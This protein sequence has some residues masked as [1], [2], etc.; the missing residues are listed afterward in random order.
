MQALKLNEVLLRVVAWHN[1]HPLARRIGPSQVHSIGEVLLPFASAQPLSGGVAAPAAPAP[2]ELARWAPRPLPGGA[3]ARPA[4]PPTPAPTPPPPTDQ[5]GPVPAAVAAAEAAET[6]DFDPFAPDPVDGAAPTA[7][8]AVDAAP[9]PG[10][11]SETDAAPDPARA[12]AR[13][14]APSDDP[15]AHLTGAAPGL[16]DGPPAPAEGPAVPAIDDA[17]DAGLARA[18]A[19]AAS[20]APPA[21]AARPGLLRRLL[22]RLRTALTGRRPG[23]PRLK[24][25]FSRDFIWPLTPRQVARWAQRHGETQPLAPADWPRREVDIDPAR[26]TG[27][28]QQG[29][30]HSVQLHLLTAAIGVG[31]RR[32]RVLMDAH[33]AI[34]GPRAYSRPR[35]ASAAVLVAAVVLSAGWGLRPAAVGG[36]ADTAMLTTLAAS[37]VDAAASAASAAVA[38]GPASAATASDTLLAATPATAEASAPVVP[39]P[40]ALPPAHNSPPSETTAHA[41]TTPA[42]QPAAEPARP[43]DPAAP[44]GRIRPALSDEQKQAARQQAAQLRAATLPTPAAAPAAPAAPTLVYAV[45]TRP[46]PLREAAARSLALMRDTSSRLPPPAPSHGELMQN[47]GQWRAAWWPFA[48]LA[49]A[50]R[51]RVMLAGRGLK[52]EVVEF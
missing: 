48:S 17:P 35:Q 42:A 29:L 51:A 33:G 16:D 13:Q 50:E 11:E 52:A 46:N 41:A 14:A 40:V 21:N 26:L 44:L 4:P 19:V 2:P 47:Q 20:A 43:P 9:E 3:A 28:R 27:L 45:V 34:I 39:G 49:D 24:P 25:A 15:P 10:A 37:A 36:G 18:H 5:A 32:I 6:A 1:R 12:S 8:A 22:A 30:A 38:A 23:L 7:A 31:D